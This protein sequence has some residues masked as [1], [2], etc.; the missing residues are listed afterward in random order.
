M[1]GKYK[2]GLVTV[3]FWWSLRILRKFFYEPICN[4]GPTAH[5]ISSM[6]HRPKDRK[7]SGLSDKKVR[8][9]R[10]DLRFLEIGESQVK[11]FETHF[12]AILWSKNEENLIFRP[13]YTKIRVL[14]S[15]AIEATCKIRPGNMFMR[16]KRLD[17]RFLEIG[18]L[19][20]IFTRRDPEFPGISGQVV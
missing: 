2:G 8:F 5:R 16:F 10:L 19:R 20:V 14:I 7:L 12:R 15:S 3:V 4:P 18:V 13:L 17:L 1:Y 6:P 9:K 11:S